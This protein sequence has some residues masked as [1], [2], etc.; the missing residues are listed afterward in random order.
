MDLVDC[1][2]ITD[3]GILKEL[4]KRYQ[5]R[6]VYSAIG[7]I[8]IAVN[9]YA[10]IPNLYEPA[11]L[12]RFS[13][14]DDFISD[15]PQYGRATKPHVWMVPSTAY[16]QLRLQRH[17]QAIVISGESGGKSHHSLIVRIRANTSSFS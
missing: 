10:A 14:V 6:D 3:V 11:L 5:T 12:T 1:D 15:A 9:P 4:N 16:Q 2:D 17:Q 13:T 7:P 8:I